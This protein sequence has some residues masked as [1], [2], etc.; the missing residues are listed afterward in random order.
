MSEAGNRWAPSRKI[1]VVNGQPRGGALETGQSDWFRCTQGC[2]I[3]SGTPCDHCGAT[4]LRSSALE[5]QRS[6]GHHRRLRFLGSE[7][8]SHGILTTIRCEGEKLHINLRFPR[9]LLQLETSWPT[10]ALR[11]FRG[12]CRSPFPAQ[13]DSS[14]MPSWSIWQCQGSSGGYMASLRSMLGILRVHDA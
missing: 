11:F 5:R 8:S 7:C 14:L 4:A 13:V 3:T 2:P 9:L 12:A 1:Q 6:T 10:N